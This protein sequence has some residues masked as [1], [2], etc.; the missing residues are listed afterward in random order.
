LSSR[1]RDAIER[2]LSQL[3]ALPAELQRREEELE[4]REAAVAAAAEAPWEGL[5]VRQAEQVGCETRT[6]QV[7]ALVE[8]QLDHLH[9]NSSAA[10]VLKTLRK[11]I[12]DL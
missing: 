11:Q 2:Q 1:T 12:L 7:L 8:Q 4:A 5:A 6:L 10:I 9:P 3:L